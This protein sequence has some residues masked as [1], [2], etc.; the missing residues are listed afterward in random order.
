MD[1]VLGCAVGNALEVAEAVD[2][3]RGGGPQDVRELSIALSAEMIASALFL[4]D[5]GAKR[6]AADALDSGRA[7]AKFTE[8]V[9][10]RARFLTRMHRRGR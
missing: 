7:Y 8:W 4:D 9:R 5:D 2:V 1:R 3:L 10:V 6:L